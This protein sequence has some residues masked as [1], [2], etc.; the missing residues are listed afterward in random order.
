M[1]RLVEVVLFLV[2]FLVVAVW[3]LL[4]PARGPSMRTV[5]ALGVMV[6]LLATALLLLRAQD[7]EPPT[8]GYVPSHVQ[9]GRVMPS[10]VAPK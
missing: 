5:A 3:R 1:L 8:A 2:P 4:L 9:N 7:A 6:V 10:S